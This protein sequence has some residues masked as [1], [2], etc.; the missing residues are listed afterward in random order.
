MM[1]KLERILF[2]FIVQFKLVCKIGIPFLSNLI[3]E[4]KYMNNH[5]LYRIIGAHYVFRRI[6][7]HAYAIFLIVRFRAHF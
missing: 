4:R 2:F 1:D 7:G 3:V 6:W 5:F